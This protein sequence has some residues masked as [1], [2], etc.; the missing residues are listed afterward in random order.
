MNAAAWLIFNLECSDHIF[1]ALI[2]LHWPWIPADI[3]YKIAVLMYKVR[4]VLH[5]DTCGFLLVLLMFPV[6]RLSVLPVQ[7]SWSCRHLNS[8]PS[9][10]EH[11]R[12]PTRRSGIHY[13]K[14]WSWRQLCRRF[15][16]NW[17]LLFQRS[18]SHQ[19]F[20]N[21]PC[22]DII[23]L[24]LLWLTDW[25]TGKWAELMMSTAWYQVTLLIAFLC[26]LMFAN[27][28]C[29]LDW[30]HDQLSKLAVFNLLMSVVVVSSQ[31]VSHSLTKHRNTLQR[32]FHIRTPQRPSEFQHACEHL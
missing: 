26:F 12:L 8:Q 30:D 17:R 28:N 25:L 31:H 32:Y 24:N 4:T 15:S 16:S 3:H 22:S 5:H 1:N 9:V 14:T 7:A 6:D 21:G 2:S 23:T 27:V 29:C 20:Y 18:F 11:L 19:H 10:A 13:L